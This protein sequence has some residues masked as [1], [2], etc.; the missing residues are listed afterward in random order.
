VKEAVEVL[1]AS[2]EGVK[3]AWNLARVRLLE[4]ITGEGGDGR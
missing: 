4:E 3:R 2:P 1:K